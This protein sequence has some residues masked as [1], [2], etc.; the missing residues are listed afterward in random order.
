MDHAPPL[1]QPSSAAT[2]A[3]DSLAHGT[4][5]DNDGATPPAPV[6]KHPTPFI[7]SAPMLDPT[8]SLAVAGVGSLFNHQGNGHQ[9]TINKCAAGDTA[10]VLFQTGMSS[11]AEMG[12]IG[13]EAWRLK[14]SAN[15]TTWAT[16]ITINGAGHTTLTGLVTFNT[17]DGVAVASTFPTVRFFD[18]DGP[19][20]SR[21]YDMVMDSGSFNLRVLN[22]AYTAA[23]SVLSATRTGLNVTAVDLGGPTSIKGALT[24]LVDEGYACGSATK[25]WSAIHATTGVIQASDAR[26]KII[27][28]SLTGRAGPM[29]DAVD[30][31]VFRW[32]E[33]TST[34][35]DAAD[36]TS[37]PPVNARRE[38]G[39]AKRVKNR[40]APRVTR[41]PGQ[42]LH[43]GFNAQD[44]K[45][46]M[47][48]TG[49]DFAAWGLDDATDA[50]S[51][52]H[53]RP[54]QLIPVLWAALKETRAEVAALRRGSLAQ[55]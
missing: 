24:P 29:I 22:D 33:G 30:P 42:R 34:I 13:D 11:R 27:E 17:N 8:C 35:E 10:S 53:L 4:T 23:N 40:P 20:E 2:H 32:R 25:R 26:D 3:L 54:D 41:T 43:A 51:R 16:P 46:A 49:L 31:V 7:K 18:S 9:L 21:Y 28:G 15:G 44:I 14:V 36:D 37:A 50:D 19:G 38:T 6:A 47:T 5:L 48:S 55:A 12:T 45:S 39:F 52:Q 1:P